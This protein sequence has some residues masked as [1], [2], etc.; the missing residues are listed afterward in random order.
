VLPEYKRFSGLVAEIQVR[1]I[2]QHAWAEIEHD[3]Q[4]K[5]ISALPTRVR[6][7][8]ASLAGLIEIADREFQAIDDENQALVREARKNV[9]LGQLAE[10]EITPDSVRAYLDKKYLP[11]GRMSDFSYQYAARMLRDLGFTNLAEVDECIE[12][13]DDDAVSRTLYGSRLGQLSRFE[14][15]LLASMGEGYLKAHRWTLGSLSNPWYPKHC[16]IKLKKLR[17]GNIP[18]GSYKPSGYPET[19]LPDDALEKVKRELDSP[20]TEGGQDDGTSQSAAQ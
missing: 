15:V 11:D 7:R 6:R 16:L 18:I 4:Y 17:D 1:T 12:K 19:V 9:D 3:I 10:V 13:Y 20:P 8:F 5:A 14:E 2:L